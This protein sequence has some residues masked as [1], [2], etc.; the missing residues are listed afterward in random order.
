MHFTFPSDL[1]WSIRPNV[2]SVPLISST[3]FIRH[4][5]DDCFLEPAV[6]G[7]RTSCKCLVLAD[8]L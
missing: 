2:N 6:G 3:D 5:I 8:I 4:V 1:S 7:T